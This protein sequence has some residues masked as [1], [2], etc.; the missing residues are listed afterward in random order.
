MTVDQPDPESASSTDAVLDPTLATATALHPSTSDTATAPLS[1]EGATSRWGGNKI[2][3]HSVQPS[4]DS[5]EVHIIQSY[6]ALIPYRLFK[7]IT[8]FPTFHASFL[9]LPCTFL[10]F[11]LLCL[12]LY[13]QSDVQLLSDSRMNRPPSY[14]HAYPVG[15]EPLAAATEPP[16]VV[17]PASMAAGIAARVD[18][19]PKGGPTTKVDPPNKVGALASKF[20]QVPKVETTP[21]IDTSSAAKVPLVPIVP[22][23][24]Q[25]AKVDPVTV[26]DQMPKAAPVSKVATPMIPLAPKGCKVPM[27]AL[28]PK[29]T[30]KVPLAAPAPVVRKP[31]PVPVVDTVPKAAIAPKIDPVPVAAAAVAAPVAAAVIAKAPLAAPV[32][33]A[34][35]VPMADPAP[36]ARAETRREKHER[37][38]KLKNSGSEPASA[39]AP[40]VKP[41]VKPAFIP[42]PPPA[43][44]PVPAPVPA[45]VPVAAS[46]PAPVALAVPKKKE[47]LFGENFSNVDDSAGAR[48]TALAAPIVKVNSDTL[49]QLKTRSELFPAPRI[50]GNPRAPGTSRGGY[51]SAPRND[52]GTPDW[53]SGSGNGYPSSSAA[54]TSQRN[55]G[56][57]AGPTPW[58]LSEAAG[59]TLPSRSP[60]TPSLRPDGP[61]PCIPFA[62][63]HQPPL[64]GGESTST[65]TAPSSSSSSSSVRQHHSLPSAGLQPTSSLPPSDPPTRSTRTDTPATAQSKKPSHPSAPPQHS[66]ASS[67]YS[68]RQERQISKC[69]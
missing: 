14:P 20:G 35:P 57:A 19:A 37:I 68:N 23:V 59:C 1:K 60:M 18:L 33:V 67:F 69:K 66:A 5:K 51:R 6:D 48:P 29:G 41:P 43:F 56:Y 55:S 26:V 24:G 47:D 34:A 4:E 15:G 32:P 64:N 27:V 7:V 62:Q 2:E 22:L 28:P 49:Q 12:L 9:S 31:D 42:L 61:K 53:S 46:V 44:N 38:F 21:K 52:H 3:G 58:H 17:A 63:T 45:P 50:V 54:G 65:T 10:S 8:L 16:P 36:P 25:V 39:P 30:P 13:L 40:V 11:L